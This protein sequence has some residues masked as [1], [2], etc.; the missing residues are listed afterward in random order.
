[1]ETQDLRHTI[2][3]L[4]FAPRLVK[5]DDMAP[6]NLTQSRNSRRGFIPSLTLRTGRV[7]VLSGLCT[8]VWNEVT[9]EPQDRFR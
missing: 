3:T 4:D 9:V 2:R 1:M 7:V 8:C 5:S 6:L